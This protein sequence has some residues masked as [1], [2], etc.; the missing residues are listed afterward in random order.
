MKHNVAK[1]RGGSWWLDVVGFV[2]FAAGASLLAATIWEIQTLNVGLSE[3][4]FTLTS[5]LQGA[6]SGIAK[7]AVRSCLPGVLLMCALYGGF[8]IYLRRWNRLHFTVHVAVRKHG[9]SLRSETLF[10]QIAVLIPI[11]TWVL[12]L[13]T[14]ERNLFLTSY[15][16][17]R[18][19]KTTIYEDHYVRPSDVEITADGKTKNIICLYM[20]SMEI[21]YSSWEAGGIQDVNLMPN[22]T[23]LAYDNV[24]FGT[25]PGGKLGGMETITDTG[26]TSAALMA[27]TSGV[28]FSFPMSDASEVGVTTTFAPR[29]ETIGTVLQ[30]RG[31][32]QEFLC[33][34]NATFGGRR[35][36][37]TG[38]GN[39]DIFDYK[40]ALSNDLLPTSDYYVW[41]GFEDFRLY[42]FAKEELL[43]LSGSDQPFNLTMLTVD[44]HFPDGYLCSLCEKD[45][46]DVPLASI[47]ECAD[48]QAAE[49]IQ[50]CTEQDFYKDTVIVVMGDHPRMDTVLVSGAD[51]ADRKIYNC[52]INADI[53]SDA[54]DPS[55]RLFSHMDLFPTMLSAMGFRIEGDRLGLGVNLFSQEPTLVEQY[56]R[57]WLNT[58]LQKTSKFYAE[59]FY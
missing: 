52:F 1:P 57:D 43:R 21:T 31:Y 51:M 34:S 37:F 55:T 7:G 24:S 33:G 49:F 19:D 25:V 29:L 12:A 11:L 59:N 39:Y 36:Y 16:K 3:I 13:F 9:F 22:L 42:D 8:L 44:T 38:H 5:P 26:W 32:R 15:I 58:E 2:F 46:Y 28:P 17:T 10:R 50:W 48:R 6:D 56:G 41:W 20:E 40:T 18:M 35:T 23:E 27:T 4:I 30:E 53:A 45:R 14:I 54:P 47:V